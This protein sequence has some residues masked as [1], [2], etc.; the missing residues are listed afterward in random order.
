MS[1]IP[2]TILTGFLGSGKT[3][4][5]L[6][7]LPQLHALNPSYRLA[8]LKNEFGDLAVDSQLAS[9]SSITSVREMLNGCICC[10]LVGSLSSALQELQD[11]L[12]V[13]VNESTGKEEKGSLDRIII[14]TSGSAFPAT[15]AMEVNRI[16]RETKGAY[17]L[18][19][20]ISVIDVENWKGYEDT[21]FTARLQAKYTD[22]VVF[23][24]WEGVS[25]R[26]FDD[27]LDRLGDLEVQV[28][29]VKSDKGKVGVDV[30]C[31]VD[32]GLARVLMDDVNG[33]GNGHNHNHKNG[34]DK[35]EHSHDH[36]SE[37]EVLS[38]T[39]RS[40]SPSST[41]SLAPLTKLLIKAPKDE[42]YR[43]KAILTSSTPIP[44]SDSTLSPP[45][46]STSASVSTSTSTS[47]STTDLVP[48]S[49]KYILN[50][51][52]GRWTST[53]MEDQ[54]LEKEH[55][56]SQ[57]EGVVLRMTIV[58]ARD[59]SNKWKKRI[60]GGGWVE[61]EGEGEGEKGELKVVR[62]L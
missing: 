15:L 3:T 42:V 28:A 32:G 33:N 31:G 27:C 9:S 55:E 34:E 2:I 25:E 4:L 8:L 30:V 46:S 47:T 23:N 18:D 12:P 22:L 29:W 17:V 56:S 61:I 48:K 36:Q 43:I 49:A 35:H 50:W 7:L 41:I 16:A 24:K 54:Q 19:G 13:K 11:S 52:F 59:E 38:I 45:E 58:T 14:E 62:I 60:E 51:A 57:G 26:R 1:P 39:L 44:P 53:K 20:V 21:S 40:T 37:V 5:I 10:N 6:N